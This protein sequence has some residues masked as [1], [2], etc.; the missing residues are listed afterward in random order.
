LPFLS[1]FAC[2]VRVGASGQAE[3]R[4][5]VTTLLFN[6]LG[7]IGPNAPKR[8]CSPR[9]F[10]PCGRFLPCC[11]EWRGREQLNCFAVVFLS[12][13][14]AERGRG[15][16]RARCGEF[17]GRRG[18]KSAGRKNGSAASAGAVK[19][20][21]GC[22]SALDAERP[23]GQLCGGVRR[24]W[25]RRSVASKAENKKSAGAYNPYRL[26]AQLSNEHVFG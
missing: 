19:Q 26:Y 4:S 14:R 24:G 12:G 18:R 8:P 2:S 21:A 7:A 1:L 16:M 15:A 13:R 9:H 22:S 25:G 6:R 23:A 11:V 17:E 20:S 10:P 3:R 5:G